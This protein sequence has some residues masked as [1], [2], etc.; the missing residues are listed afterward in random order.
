MRVPVA[1]AEAAASEVRPPPPMPG[2]VRAAFAAAATPRGYDPELADT[3]TSWERFTVPPSLPSLASSEPPATSSAARPAPD[4]HPLVAAAVATTRAEVNAKRGYDS[5][6]ANL[7]TSWERSP[8]VFARAAGAMP[9]PSVAEGGSA[10]R[11]APVQPALVTA[12]I[13][14]ARSARG[15]YAASRGDNCAGGSLTSWE[16]EAELLRH[17]RLA[18]AAAASPQ[19]IE[20]RPSEAMREAEAGRPRGAS[21]EGADSDEGPQLSDLARSVGALDAMWARH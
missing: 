12:A 20:A 16:R 8:P 11:A 15:G 2:F 9:P 7:C 4:R 1:H 21:A 17:M 13:A 6:V 5:H 3:R 10:V 18:A 14:E 19:A